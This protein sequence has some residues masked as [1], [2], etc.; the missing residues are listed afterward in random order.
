MWTKSQLRPS[1]PETH[2]HL[3]HPRGLAPAPG[4]LT[5]PAW[6][7]PGH[8]H[9]KAPLRRSWG[10]VETGNKCTTVAGAQLSSTLPPTPAPACPG[11][12]HRGQETRKCCTSLTSLHW[13]FPSST[14]N[15]P[16][17][18]QRLSICENPLRISFPSLRCHAPAPVRHGC[19]WALSAHFTSQKERG[20]PGRA[21]QRAKA[22][23]HLPPAL[24][25]H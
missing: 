7:Q 3:N 11:S 8:Q 24:P 12:S 5:S 10:A 4:M 16:L 6:G 2:P 15:F 14:W 17:L 1:S 18:G 13:G 23:A 22:L 20:I 19:P 9:F 25:W 21:E